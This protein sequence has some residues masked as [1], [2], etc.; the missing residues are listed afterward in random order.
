MRKK[1][2]VLL[3]ALC[4][5]IGSLPFKAHAEELCCPNMKLAYRTEYVYDS[6]RH[7]FFCNFHRQLEVCTVRITYTYRV[8]YC[9]NCG[10]EHGR[11]LTYIKTL[12]S[13]VC[14]P[15]Q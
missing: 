15:E 13:N 11:T 2:L 6:Q 14:C 8:Q 7:D 3:V 10:A 12:H 9:T 1:I 4:M 5:T